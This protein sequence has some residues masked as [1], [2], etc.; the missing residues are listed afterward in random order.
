MKLVARWTQVAASEARIA[1][2]ERLLGSCYH[3]TLR[4]ITAGRS[5]DTDTESLQ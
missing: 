3:K 1:R 2:S 4:A 5:E